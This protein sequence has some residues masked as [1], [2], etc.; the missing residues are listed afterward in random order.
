VTLTR[1]RTTVAAVGMAAV[2]VLAIAACGSDNT[3]SSTTTSAAG[4]TGSS[5]ASTSGITC[6]TGSLTASGSTAQTNAMSAW[7]AAYQKACSGAEINYQ[8]GGSGK[9]YTDFVAG[10][11]DFAGSDYALSATQAPAADKRCGAGNTAIDLP[12]TPGAIAVGY[13]LPGITTLKL[14][15][16]TLGSIFSGKIKKWNDPTIVAENPGVTLPSTTISTFH[17]SDT[18]GTSFNFSN[19]LTHDASSTWTF[20]ANKQWPAGAG[21]QGEKGSSVVAQS[22]KSTTGGIGYFEDSYAT[23]SGIPAAEIGD[24]GGNFIA[25]SDA[26]TT[27]FLSHATVTGTNGDLALTFDYTSASSTEYPNVLVTYEIVCSAGNKNAALLKGFLGYTAGTGQS[28]L[29]GAGYVPLPSNIQAQVQAAV[30]KLS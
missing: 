8:A 5:A 24:S 11:D 10:T 30:A 15:A 4:G 29:T 1:G 28:I 18:S 17:R 3:T 26:A 22:V 25:P 23:Q 20:G 27:A 16:A 2:G 21:G 12:M 6:A 7:T 9:G 13:N 14:S 19:Y